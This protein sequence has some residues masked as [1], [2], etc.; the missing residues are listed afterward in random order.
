MVWDPA[1][2]TPKAW[3]SVL[4][5]YRYVEDR[6]DDFR[7][8]RQLVEHVAAQA[9]AASIAVATSGTALLVAPQL[10]PDWA[11]EAMRIDV[12]L[13]GSIRFTLPQKRLVKPATFEC[14]G[15]KVVTVFESFLRQAKWVSR[16]PG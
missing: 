10:E 16:P 14:E 5:F 6:N 8:L 11:H 3:E 13:G 9:Y 1:R 2:I 15:Q 12:D 4:E 7:P